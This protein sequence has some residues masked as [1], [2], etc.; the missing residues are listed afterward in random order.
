MEISREEIKKIVELS[1]LEY[2]EEDYD[3][4]AKDLG[5]ILAFVDQLKNADIPEQTSFSREI[6]VDNLRE[7]ILG[8]CISREDALKN[9]PSH[10][11]TAFTV[12][13]VVE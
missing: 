7:D 2:A 8:E 5:Q 1:A 12:P 3:A 4:L 9:A 13:K 6:E 10:N 11:D